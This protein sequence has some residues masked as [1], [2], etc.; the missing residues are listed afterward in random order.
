M[1]QR[2]IVFNIFLFQHHDNIQQRGY[3]HQ[4]KYFHEVE[5]TPLSPP[6][7]KKLPSKSPALLGLLGLTAI[8]TWL[9]VNNWVQYQPQFKKIFCLQTIFV[10]GYR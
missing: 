9:N 6:P 2:L 7:Q 3:F 1:K 8:K 4:V 5:C 10:Q